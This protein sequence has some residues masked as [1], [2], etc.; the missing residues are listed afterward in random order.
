MIGE[1]GG[2]FIQWLRG[3]YYV[4]KTGS[5]SRAAAEMGR[6]QPA[7][8][9]QIKNLESELGVELFVRAKGKMVLTPPGEKLLAN[10]VVLFEQINKM[11]DDLKE[12]REDLEGTVSIATS[13][14]IIRFI[15]PEHIVEFNKIHPKVRFDIQGGDLQFITQQVE[16]SDAD[17]AFFP[18]E[19][20]PD[21]F[22]ASVLLCSRLVLLDSRKS[23]LLAEGDEPSLRGIASVPYV[24]FHKGSTICQLT[25]RVFND[26]GLAKKTVLVLNDFDEIKK[27]VELG[28][29]VS[30]LDD[31]SIFPTDHDRF[32]VH[33]MNQYIPVRKHKLITLKRKYISP[34]AKAFIRVLERDAQE[35]VDSIDNYTY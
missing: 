4:S 24:D 26:A 21:R 3:F 35:M 25:D 30:L 7:I 12:E 8:S 28:M 20:V 33:A 6:A 18:M 29:G 17:F 31:Y 27:Y 11:K 10:T 34:P 15:L 32:I 9:H 14:S 5:V 2:D 16:S 23:P 1:I 13:P 19:N 22:N